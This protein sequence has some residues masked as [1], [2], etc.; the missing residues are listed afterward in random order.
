[1]GASVEAATGLPGIVLT[2]ALAVAVCFWLLVAIGAATVDTFDADADLDAWNMG[3][4]P[5]TVALS[6]LTALAWILHVALTALLALVDTS[7]A[8]VVVGHLLAP[9]G[10][11]LVAWRLTCRFVRP[12]R[13][14][15]PDD[16]VPSQPAGCADG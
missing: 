7:G 9:C 1:M 10:A 6:L 15:F 13:R 12:L 3:G 4:V 16:P 2:A 11:L 8:T 5:V 14:L